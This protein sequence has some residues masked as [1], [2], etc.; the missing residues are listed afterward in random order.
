MDN[1][2]LRE[3]RRQCSLLL[4]DLEQL[5]HLY[6]L[7]PSSSSGIL[8]AAAGGSVKDQRLPTWQRSNGALGRAVEKWSLPRAHRAYRDVPRY[9]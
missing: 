2:R 4:K 9:M 8:W 3:W 5:E 6:L 7:E 1:S